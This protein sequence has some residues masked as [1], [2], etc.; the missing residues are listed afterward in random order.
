VSNIHIPGLRDSWLDSFQQMDDITATLEQSLG[1]LFDGGISNAREFFATLTQGIASIFAQLAAKQAAEGF[2]SFLGGLFG[3]FGKWTS[4]SAATQA[5]SGLLDNIYNAAKGRAFHR[6][7]EI[8]MATGGVVS[9]PTVMPM[10]SGTGLMGEAGPEAVMP[11]KRTSGG[12]LGVSAAMPSITIVN[13]LGVPAT[14]R[15]ERSNDRMTVVMEAAQLG[16]SLAQSRI[17]RSLRTGYG[18]TAQSIQRTYGLRRK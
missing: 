1:G 14:A 10:A 16:A 4:A 7:W 15:M 2:T 8:P 17:S 3:G 9:G 13:R 18:D 11:L 12:R 5:G 6:G